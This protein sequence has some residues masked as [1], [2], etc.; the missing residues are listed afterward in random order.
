MNSDLFDFFLTYLILFTTSE[1]I[2]SLQLGLVLT[3]FFKNLLIF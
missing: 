2:T 1:I 3:H